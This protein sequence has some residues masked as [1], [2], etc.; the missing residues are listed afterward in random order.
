MSE[1]RPPEAIAEVREE[2]AQLRD[3]IKERESSVLR[4]IRTL[5]DDTLAW[6]RGEQSFPRAASIGLAFAYLRPRIVLVVGSVAAIVIAGIQLWMLLRQLDISAQ[7]NELLKQQNALIEQQGE[8]VRQQGYATKAQIAASLLTGLDDEGFL[9]SVQLES[10]SIYGDV[11][12]EILL[13]IVD[14]PY[15]S[16]NWQPDRKWL[17]AAFV[18]AH[19][20]PKLTAQQA[21]RVRE[22]IFRAYF[23]ASTQCHE[24]I[25]SRYPRDYVSPGALRIEDFEE[26]ARPPGG[27]RPGGVKD[28]PAPS[29]IPWTDG[30]KPGA[31]EERFEEV[32]QL[33]RIFLVN[34]PL[35][36]DDL[37]ELNDVE[38]GDLLQH[39]A[40]VYMDRYALGKVMF[41]VLQDLDEPLTQLCRATS[42][43]KIDGGLV[44][45]LAFSGK[46][47]SKSMPKAH[48]ST[49]VSIHF[50]EWCSPP[51]KRLYPELW[52]QS[53]ES[54]PVMPAPE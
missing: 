24:S 28:Q 47:L 40:R 27:G 45:K 44:Y 5:V 34:R 37:A 3:E 35:S 32:T 16:F 41:L 50:L 42:R 20:A 29:R 17:N 53:S 14:S 1:T 13:R 12:S 39:A 52:F 48:V 10:L 7:Q 18:L 21:K 54:L 23:N 38:Q 11:T 43:R 30:G 8:L 31:A 2:L 19:N 36:A 22:R 25:K 15:R 6:R 26:L 33:L 51:E 49:F 46:E 4:A 9:S